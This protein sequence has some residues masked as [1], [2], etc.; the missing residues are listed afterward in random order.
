MRVEAIR[1]NLFIV[2]APKCGTTALSEY[3]RD[4]PGLFMSRP[5]EPNFFCEDLEKTRGVTSL[6]S[7]LQLF[8]NADGQ[9]VVGEAS[10]WYLYSEVALERIWQFNPN[11]KI[12]A[13]VRNPIDLVYSLH[14]QLVYNQIETERTFEKAWRLQESRPDRPFLQY[15][16][17]GMLGR[18][19]ERLLRIFPREQVSIVVFDDFTESPGAVYHDTLAFLGL[20]SDGR[21]EFPK[22]NENKQNRVQ[23]V[24]K[25]AR[26]TPGA[27]TSIT[28]QVKQVLG[29]ER[30]GL[31]DRVRHANTKRLAR[32]PLPAALREELAAFFHEDIVQLSE[33]LDRDL[34]GWSRGSSVP[35]LLD[36]T[37]S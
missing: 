27:L 36:R 30:L 19:I 37:P 23:W 24:A 2:G 3:L 5:K 11:A 7:Y 1:P 25:F 20:P 26:R 4:H 9:P 15:A 13:M 6:G 28:D 31:L 17:I 12:I 21:T 16:R 14:S 35:P 22:I 10:T 8:S 34:T 33:L 18:Q 32:H 29:I